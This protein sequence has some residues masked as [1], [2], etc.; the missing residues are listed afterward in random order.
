MARQK[1]SG[2]P[3]ARHEEQIMTIQSSVKAADWGPV[4]AISFAQ[5]H[6]WGGITS[7]TLVG[8]RPRVNAPHSAAAAQMG[9]DFKI[10][11]QASPS[12]PDWIGSPVSDVKGTMPLIAISW[13]WSWE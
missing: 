5:V 6:Q 13:S 1:D 10:A 3:P 7:S 9:T 11:G 12:V 2:F 8:W 4:T